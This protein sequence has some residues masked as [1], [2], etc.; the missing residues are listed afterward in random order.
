MCSTRTQ[1][2]LCGSP[3]P[4]AGAPR[5]NIYAYGV[6][7]NTS[8]PSAGWHG[9]PQDQYDSVIL[10]TADLGLQPVAPLPPRVAVPWLQRPET[11][12]FIIGVVVIVGIA[13][14]LLLVLVKRKQPPAPAEEKP[15]ASS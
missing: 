1:T 12:F 8:T 10:P 11:W 6:D 14:L 2:I 9:A 3:R 4:T 13:T 7:S 5:D 15:A